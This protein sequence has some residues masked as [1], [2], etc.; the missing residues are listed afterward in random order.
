MDGFSTLATL[1]HVRK[2]D[3]ITITLGNQKNGQRRDAVMHHKA[4]LN[5]PLCP[6]TRAAAQRF[7]QMHLCDLYNANDIPILYAPQKYDL[8]IHHMTGGIQIAR[9]TLHSTIWLQG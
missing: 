4:F 2:A 8:A 9:S 6:C 7:M 5:N 1:V 3:A